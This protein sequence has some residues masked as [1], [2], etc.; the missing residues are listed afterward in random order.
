MVIFF[1][2]VSVYRN[3]SPAGL[4]LLITRASIGLSRDTSYYGYVARCRDAGVPLIAYHFLKSYQ[5]GA[6]PEE[7]AAFAYD[8]VGSQTPLMLDAEPHTNRNATVDEMVRF[9]DRYR[10]LGGMVGLAYIPRWSWQ[11]LGSPSLAPV[12]DRG[13]GLVSS[14]YV[15]Y[16]Y[17]DDHQGWNPYGGYDYVS[18]LQYTDR[19][20]YGGTTVDFNAYRGTVE[21]LL[22]LSKG[23]V[24]DESATYFYW[25]D[26][27]ESNG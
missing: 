4:P 8:T 17:R 2:D 27:S 18:V 6:G 25:Y 14:N 13:L 21:D 22:R 11:Q 19:Q 9:I 3:I 5:L 20:P 26:D 16:S 23:P 24:A 12:R 1:P 15:G 10:E 7:Q